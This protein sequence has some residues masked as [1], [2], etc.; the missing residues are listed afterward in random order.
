[1]ASKEKQSKVG[2]STKLRGQQTGRADTT[3]AQ[4]REA[5]R[6]TP[7]LRGDRKADNE[8]FG[9][10]SS[11]HVGGDSATPRSNTASVP[12]AMPSGKRVGETGGE[13]VFKQRQ[14]RRG[15]K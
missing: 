8:M 9:D 14:A 5:M 15:K 4:D 10:D 1:M 6:E 12:A 3:P 2:R 13:K 7:A 11:Q